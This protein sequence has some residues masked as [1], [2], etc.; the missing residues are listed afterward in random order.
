MNQPFRLGVLLV[1]SPADAEWRLALAEAI[2]HQNGLLIKELSGLAKL[3]PDQNCVVLVANTAEALTVGATHWAILATDLHTAAS[4]ASQKNPGY[5]RKAYKLVAERLAAISW[6]EANGA[7]VLDAAELDLVFPAL[8]RV[9][10][11]PTALAPE[12]DIPLGPLEL[13]R[14]NP[15][16]IGARTVLPMEVFVFKPSSSPLNDPPKIDLTGRARVVVFGP[17][18]DLPAGHWRVTT[19][20]AVTT[21]GGDIYLKLQWGVGEDLETIDVLL[22]NSGTY[23]IVLDHA[24]ATPGPAEL[25]IWAANAHFVGLMEFFGAEIERLPDRLPKSDLE[26]TSDLVGSEAQPS[27]MP[28]PPSAWA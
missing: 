15:P 24:W 25:R 4:V 17:R 28:E 13:Y 14:S 9:V 20:F 21:E 8:G 3:A 26:A 27:Y 7:V 6:L 18:H 5:P 11:N 16:E 23:E 19:K 1:P 10:R 2:R 12:L 22:Q